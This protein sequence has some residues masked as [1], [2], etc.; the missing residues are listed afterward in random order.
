MRWNSIDDKLSNWMFPDDW[1]KW[2]AWRPVRLGDTC[3]VVWLE[4]VERK[5]VAHAY[6]GWMEY[7]SVI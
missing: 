3:T 1:Q 4:Y 6:G 5:F 2:F 7:R